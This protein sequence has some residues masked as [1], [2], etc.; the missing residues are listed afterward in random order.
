[1]RGVPVTDTPPSLAMYEAIRAVNPDL[2]PG[3]DVLE[4]RIVLDADHPTTA[5]ME[6]RCW[7]RLP[8]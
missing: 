5:I 3:G 8:G 2:P 1:M 4:A 7:V 6:I